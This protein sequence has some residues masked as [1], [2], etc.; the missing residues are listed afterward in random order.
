MRVRGNA[1]ADLGEVQVHH[2]GIG[3]R[4]HQPRARAARWADRAEQ[5]GP[6]IA[7][8]AGRDRARAALGPEAGERALL[9]NASL[10][11]PPELQRLSASVLRQSLVYEGG[12]A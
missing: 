2:V 1:G 4:Q 8:V 9:A 10:V 7:L 6:G 12:E 3:R 5:V 11:L